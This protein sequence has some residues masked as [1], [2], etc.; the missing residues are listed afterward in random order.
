MIK[1]LKEISSGGCLYKVKSIKNSTSK[2]AFLFNHEITSFNAHYILTKNLLKKTDLTL[3]IAYRHFFRKYLKSIF[4]VFFKVKIKSLENKKKFCLITKKLPN[5]RL[6]FKVKKIMDDFLTEEK[7]K[8]NTDEL[9]KRFFML[10]SFLESDDDE[11]ES[12]TSTCQNDDDGKMN[13]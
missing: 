10:N 9:K 13:F 6:Y 1:L 7:N 4:S 11:S 8:F 12:N 2:L 3:S 5:Q